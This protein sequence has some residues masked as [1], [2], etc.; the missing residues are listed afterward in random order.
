VS[1]F[2]MPQMIVDATS[3]TEKARKRS[4]FNDRL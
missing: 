1:A 2:E 4:D 3:I